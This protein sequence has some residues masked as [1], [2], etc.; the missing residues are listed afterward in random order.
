MTFGSP[1]SSPQFGGR[2]PHGAPSPNAGAGHN[3]GSGFGASG[4]PSGFGAPDPAQAPVPRP[5]SGEPSGPGTSFG[6]GSG[7][8]SVPNQGTPAGSNPHAGS[9]TGSSFGAPGSSDGFGQSSPAPDYRRQVATPTGPTKGPWPLLIAG[10]VSAVIALIVLVLAPLVASP[11]QGLYFGLAIAGW[12]LAGIV[13]FVL[14][15]LYTL[16]NTQRQAE[17]FYVEDTT[18]TL[19]YRIIMGGSFLLVIAAAVEIAFYV[20]KVVGA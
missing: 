18:Q 10:G 9:S 5:G 4:G 20:G 14:L 17:T 1:G 11:T 8:G 19:L 7:F 13:A 15:G 3:A 12:L 16:K 2:P 6:S